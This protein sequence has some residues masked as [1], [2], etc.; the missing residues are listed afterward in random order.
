[1]CT[2]RWATPLQTRFKAGSLP[3]ASV[4]LRMARPTGGQRHVQRAP[5]SACSWFSL[6]FDRAAPPPR[7]RG[8]SPTAGGGKP[9]R[10]ACT[11]FQFPPGLHG[12]IFPYTTRRAA[13]RLPAKARLEACLS[14]AVLRRTARSG[15]TYLDSGLN[16]HDGDGSSAAPADTDSFGPTSAAAG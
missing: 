5:G 6:R 15:T 13:R 14:Q 16:R 11:F 3:P 1:W 8:A 4:R 7:R 2:P 12:S 9:L 10:G